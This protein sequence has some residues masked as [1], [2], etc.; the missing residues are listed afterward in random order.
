M[1]DYRDAM[2]NLLQAAH[3]YAP[4]EH[5]RQAITRMVTSMQDDGESPSDIG[6][7]IAHAIINGVQ[8]GNWIGR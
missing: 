3:V 5:V 6:V 4:D 1:S 7:Q 2:I 8:H